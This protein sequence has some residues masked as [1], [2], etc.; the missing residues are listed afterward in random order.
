MASAS[1]SSPLSFAPL[2]GC[3]SSDSTGVEILKLGLLYARHDF[4]TEVLGELPLFLDGLQDCGLALLQLRQVCVAVE[5][6]MQLHLVHLAGPFFPVPCDKRT[7]PPS[8]AAE[9]IA[10]LNE[11]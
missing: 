10:D 4:L 3:V 7:V 11:L 2:P 6:R 8:L 5:Q 9:R 1:D